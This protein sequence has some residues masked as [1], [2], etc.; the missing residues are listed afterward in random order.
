[1]S[2]AGDGRIWLVARRRLFR[3][4]DVILLAVTVA[5]ALGLRVP[6]VVQYLPFALGLVV[7]GLP[8]GALDHLVPARLEG[9]RPTFHSVGLV[10]VLYA[11]G[12]GAVAAAWLVAPVLAFVGFIALTWF[13]WGQGDLVALLAR[14]ADGPGPA[15]SRW[16][17]VLVV[18]LRGALPMLVPLVAF[19]DVYVGVLDDTTRAMGLS[20]DVAGALVTP[21][22]RFALAAG[23]VLL[24]ATTFATLGRAAR[25]SPTLRPE[26][27]GELGEVILLAAFF[28]IV[29]PVLAVGLYFALWHS[30]RHIVRLAAIDP[31]L[32]QPAS[33]GRFGRVLVGFT[34]EALPLTL[35]AV[36]LLVGSALVLSNGASTPRSLLAIYLVLI[37]ALT[38]PHVVVVSLM[39]R[40]Q[41]VWRVPPKRRSGKY[42]NRAVIPK[43]NQR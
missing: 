5:F 23:L 40:R 21:G 3:P 22:L 25:R 34:L 7:F 24:A 17:R 39:D 11:M 16:S 8:H 6:A 35:A 2:G 28:A 4:V 18:A 27:R 41:H 38:V 19:P 15:G 37:S 12:G 29:P 32:R 20:G 10:V 26:V 1:M 33:E 30:L 31:A 42:V 43:A 9:R 13:H 14:T 36:A